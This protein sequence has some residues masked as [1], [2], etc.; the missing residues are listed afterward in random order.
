M[1]KLQSRGLGQKSVQVI[2]LMVGA[3]VL[4]GVMV[5]GCG[6]V[7]EVGSGASRSGVEP[8]R[9]VYS[10]NSSYSTASSQEQQQRIEKLAML[11]R[12]A[13]KK[14][15]LY[16]K[17]EK[18]LSDVMTSLEPAQDA[19]EKTALEVSIKAA[20]IDQEQVLMPTTVSAGLGE[21]PQDY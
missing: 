13:S 14:T 4:A 7:G 20:L 19:P 1:T 18:Q 11:N 8:V 6:S 5:S 10:Y 9:G 21:E 15:N 12:K 16:L 3:T 2:V 17:R